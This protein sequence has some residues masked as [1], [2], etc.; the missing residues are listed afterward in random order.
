MDRVNI[1]GRWVG[2]GEPCF[3]TAEPGSNHDGKLDQAKRLIEIAAESGCD[4]VKFQTFKADKIV[5]RV[6][7]RPKY[8]E[9]LAK[10]GET[11]HSLFEK[12]QLPDEWHGELRDHA[13]AHGL[14]FYSTPFDEGS[15]DMLEAL[16]V[17]CFKVAS[18]ELNHLPLVEHLAMK[19]RPMILSTGM[20]DLSDVESA[21]A[22]VYPHHHDVVLL[23]CTS[24][25]PAKVEDSNLRAMETLRSAFQVPVGLSD[26][27]EGIQVP[28]AA[29]ALGACA[30]EKHFTI[31]RSLP[32]PDH[33]FALNP[34]EL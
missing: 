28:A 16:G 7:D 29:V 23:H 12:L 5:A 30:I 31:D 25:Y 4:A 32:G 20:A 17:P 1:G 21:L 3:I 22:V 6:E 9:T 34:K 19:K 24:S 27:S 18:F 14:I 26:H 2:A 15:A 8:L 11:M 13:K 33:P 10:P